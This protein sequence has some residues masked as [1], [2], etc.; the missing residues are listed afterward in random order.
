M[1]KEYA[2]FTH[3]ECENFP[4]HDRADPD[5]FN[6][7]FCYCPLYALEDRCGG[8]FVYQENGVKDCSGCLYPHRSENYDEIISRYNEIAAG[9][10]RAGQ[11][12]RCESGQNVR[13][14]N[15]D[16]VVHTMTCRQ[17]PIRKLTE[18]KAPSQ[19]AEA[20]KSLLGKMKE[21]LDTF[22]DGVIAILITIMVLEI[23]FP[24]GAT[25]YGTFL[26][27]ILIFLVSFFVVADFWYESHRT[28]ASFEK[29][30]H[31]V[32]VLDFLFLASLAL[33]PVMT[34]W[35]MNDFSS[36][37]VINYGM[38]YFLTTIF[39][40]LIFF[41]AH[42][43]EAKKYLR[44]YIFTMVYRVIFI[45]ALNVA[46]MVLALYRPW[47]AMILYLLLPITSFFFPLEKLKKKTVKPRYKAHLKTLSR[48]RG[49]SCAAGTKPESQK[50]AGLQSGR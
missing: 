50:G 27:D 8:D 10:P 12:P 18:D 43:H 33:V 26:E 22:N 11:A 13:I 24:S 31:S 46:L 16:G 3:H 36:R 44:Q 25:S 32:V 39:E 23:P 19:A 28:F 37:A 7:L 17:R 35:I 6:C 30:G 4:C 38:V 49:Q 29:A 21:H 42:W 15:H 48:S 20:E 1:T 34:K 9:E 14:R 5:D 45:M 2:Y 47:I 40:L 41:G